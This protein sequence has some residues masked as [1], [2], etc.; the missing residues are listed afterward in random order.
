MSVGVGREVGE[1]RGDRLLLRAGGA[2]HDPAEYEDPEAVWFGRKATRQLTFGAGIH[3][4]LG[5]TLAR[6][7]LYVVRDEFHGAVPDYHLAAG[8]S[9]GCL[10]GQQK[11][12]PNYVPITYSRSPER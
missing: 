3:R 1:Q 6:P 11:V 4:W 9:V 8:E 2:N 7:E 12:L 10:T 5:A